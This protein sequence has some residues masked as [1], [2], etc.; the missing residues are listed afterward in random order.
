MTLVADLADSG[1]NPAESPY[2]CRLEVD[3]EEHHAVIVWTETLAFHAA[4]NG[5]A[6]G[7]YASGEDDWASLVDG[8]GWLTPDAETSLQV[9]LAALLPPAA[10][11]ATVFIADPRNDEPSIT[12]EVT[13][14]YIEGEAYEAWLDRIGWPVIA[15]LINVTDP[16]AFNSPYLF[17]ASTFQEA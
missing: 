1:I 14:D 3:V 16:G 15:T 4:Y 9:R 10:I 7:W 13:T 12:F 17:D 2:D 11:G 6:K 8:D 5:P